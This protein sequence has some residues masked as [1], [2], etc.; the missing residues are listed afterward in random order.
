MQAKSNLSVEPLIWSEIVSTTSTLTSRERHSQAFCGCS[1]FSTRFFNSYRIICNLEFISEKKKITSWYNATKTSEIHRTSDSLQQITAVSTSL[2]LHHHS[3]REAVMAHVGQVAACHPKT[4]HLLGGLL[5]PI[6]ST[7]HHSCFLTAH[8]RQRR[9]CV[10]P[11][12]GQ[13]MLKLS[14]NHW[15]ILF[16]LVT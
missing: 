7:T 15:N 13:V 9:C 1:S 11:S 16:L 12:G 10:T 14:S 4:D 8:L 3:D 6:S 5:A 2:L